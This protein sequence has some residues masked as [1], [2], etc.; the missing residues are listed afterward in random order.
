MNFLTVTWRY[1]VVL[2]LVGALLVAVRPPKT[3]TSAYFHPQGNPSQIKVFVGLVV[4]HA[5]VQ[6]HRGVAV[7]GLEK[8]DFQ[9]FEDGVLQRV[10][11]FSHEDIPVTVGLIVDNSG[12]MKPKRAEVVAAASTFA[13]A[14]NPADQMFVVNFNEKVT[15]GLPEGTLFTDQAA[16]L[17]VALTRTPTAGKTALYDAISA[18]FE[19]LKR[20]DRDKKVLI[21]ISDGGDNASS[22]NL[23][24]IMRLAARSNTIIYTIGLFD[25]T[26]ND[27]NPQVLKELARD[28]GGEAYMPE[29]VSEVVPL[30]ARIARDIRNQYTIAYAPTNGAQDGAH[31][32]ILV[33]ASARGQGRLTV[34]TR[35]GYD[36][37]VKSGQNPPGVPPTNVHSSQGPAPVRRP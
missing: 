21:V 5:T 36:A 28:T 10:E 29:S 34:R 13:R 14:S 11:V 3:R 26:D 27:R 2:L 9:V 37:P 1:L 12:S 24:E 20:G 32:T 7:S 30:C 22:S 23:K 8:G 4:L 17:E 35:T 15:F 18:G 25:E 31:R 16:P 19:H 6:N 33:K